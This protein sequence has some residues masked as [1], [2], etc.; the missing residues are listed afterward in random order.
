MHRRGGVIQLV[1]ADAEAGVK[2]IMFN[3]LQGV[4]QE[5][6]HEAMWDDMLDDVGSDVGFTS[7]GMYDDALMLRLIDALAA[8]TS[9]TRD[10]TLRWFGR[11]A[12]PKLDE[13]YPDLVRVYG[14]TADLVGHLDH[15]IHPEVHKVY[16]DAELPSFQVRDTEDGLIITYRSAKRL[17]A[18]AEGFIFGAAS[19]FDESVELAHTAC[20]HHGADSCVMVC[21]IRGGADVG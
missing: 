4:V 19:V 1:G 3:L 11:H 14:C 5:K 13:R 20:M 8:R 17:C 12:F 7:L 10:D 15:V 2:G 9:S 6:L 16:P 18:L 21:T